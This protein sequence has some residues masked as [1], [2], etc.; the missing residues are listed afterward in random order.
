MKTKTYFMKKLFLLISLL[1]VENIFSQIIGFTGSY[2]LQKPE[3][4][5]FPDRV[6]QN[7]LKFYGAYNIHVDENNN[8]IY[9]FVDY[10]YDFL[11]FHQINYGFTYNSLSNFFLNFF[12]FGYSNV[13]SEFTN[14]HIVDLNPTS[15]SDKR[16]SMYSMHNFYLKTG[17][18]IILN[19]NSK[20]WYFSFYPSFISLINTGNSVSI[21]V[22]APF[23]N[24][25]GNSLYRDDYLSRITSFNWGFN[26]SNHLDY[27]INDNLFLSL[28]YSIQILSKS[29]SQTNPAAIKRTNEINENLNLGA[30]VENRD[31]PF[32][33]YLFSM[34][35]KYIPRTIKSQKFRRR[36]NRL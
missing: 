15:F 8:I 18:S 3:N 29:F 1:Y 36:L 25:T 5:F 26:L 11:K 6:I 24:G 7:D 4:I 21:E 32:L 35:V 31:G 30:I 9:N 14:T 27:S 17:R 10:H 23:D 34:S 2:S 12:E 13:V 16:L 19:Y 33:N 20:N 22:G 28:G